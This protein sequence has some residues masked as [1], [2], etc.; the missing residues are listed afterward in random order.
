[1]AHVGATRYTSF[2]R[3]GEKRASWCAAVVLEIVANGEEVVMGLRTAPENCPGSVTLRVEETS[4]ETL[5]PLATGRV[6]CLQMNLPRG[7]QALEATEPWPPPNA[8]LRSYYQN[9]ETPQGQY[10]SLSEPEEES[11]EVRALKA[12]LENMRRELEATRQSVREAPAASSAA[13]PAPLLQPAELEGRG[14]SAALLR[15]LASAR[16]LYQLDE[17]ESDEEED[18]EAT[19]LQDVLRRAG[20]SQDADLRPRSRSTV[21]ED[22]RETRG[23]RGG[24]G[25]AARATA[26]ETLE[27]SWGPKVD[28][29]EGAMPLVMLELVKELRQLKAGA[30][31]D[32]GGGPSRSGTVARSLRQYHKLKQDIIQ[33]PRRFV[34]EYL[35]MVVE[36]VGVSEGQPLNLRDWNR[37]LS[38]GKHKSLER[39]HLMLCEILT[40]GLQRKEDEQNAR[41][42]QCLKSIHQARI[43]EGQWKTAWLLTGIEPPHSQN[44][45]GGGEREMEVVSQYS[46]MLE[47]LE[48]KVHGGQ[49]SAE[50]AEADAV[51]EEEKPAK[52]GRRKGGGRGA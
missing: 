49:L 21:P 17:E 39:M 22:R 52:G 30:E 51:D 28:G 1:M 44:R 29:T 33:N 45:F 36:K 10:V 13:P 26:A 11:G 18:G 38:W 14:A 35:E 15:P 47:Q 7:E 50:V 46:A 34:V 16:R 4:G 25:A 48:K 32:S 31:E 19:L 24:R 43:D 23:D 27:A 8:I 20:M 41:I 3:A 6:R 12:D 42:V 37:K 5:V 9:Q 2:V 40:L